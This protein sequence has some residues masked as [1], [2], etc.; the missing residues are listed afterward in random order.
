M[1]ELWAGTHR[2]S[3]E[4]EQAY[5]DA[6]AV[7]LLTCPVKG[8]RRMRDCQRRAC[9]TP[10]PA[11][12]SEGRE[13]LAAFH[14]MLKSALAEREAGRSSAALDA[15]RAANDERRRK[16]AWKRARDARSEGQLGVEER[17][18]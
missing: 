7:R 9:R 15:W 16:L 17:D 5:L 8:C 1:Q 10:Y 14:H 11:S 6:R 13:L 3:D 2:W 18:L 12:E 4:R